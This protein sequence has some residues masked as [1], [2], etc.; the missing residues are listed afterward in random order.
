MTAPIWRV[1]QHRSQIP[2]HT[3]A[4]PLPGSRYAVSTKRGLPV[5]R[6]KYSLIGQDKPDGESPLLGWASCRQILIQKTGRDVEHVVAACR[7]LEF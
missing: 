3:I 6:R 7:D 4:A 1:S 5:P 2:F